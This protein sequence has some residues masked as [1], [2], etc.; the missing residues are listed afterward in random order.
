MSHGVSPI[1]ILY[2]T[3]L[4]PDQKTGLGYWGG[5][6]RQFYEVSRRAARMGAKVTI[7]TCRFPG[8]SKRDIV[9][10][11]EV[12]RLGLSRDPS[13]GGVLRS[14]FRVADYIYRTAKKATETD[15]DVIHCNAFYPVL[16]G[17]LASAVSGVPMVSTFHDI[18]T[19]RTWQEVTSP[20]WGTLGHLLVRASAQAAVGTVIAVSEQT[21]T[22]LGA[23]GRKGIAV[24]PNG[25]DVEL[26]DAAG[27]QKKKDQVLYVGRLV[28]Y[29]RVD[30]LIRAFR[31]V[32]GKLPEASLIIVGDGPERNA[33]E[34]L[35]AA[36][37]GDAIKFTGTVP[38]HELVAQIF[39]ESALFVLPSVAEGEGISLKEAMAA[40]VPVIAADVPGSGV[41]G[42]VR[43]NVNGLLVSPDDPEQLAEAI[44]R[45]LNDAELRK[46]MGANGRRTAEA[47]TW[48]DA[49]G[50]ILGIYQRVT[51]KR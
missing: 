34:G 26:L 39:K 45:V 49:A 23:L 14:P 41:L 31:I 19:K 43:D 35:A 42:V 17:R 51:K 22:K 2:L 1:R 37:P 36:A 16:A 38:S 30:V 4:F 48:D 40:S 47:W 24:V 13:T 3:E 44:L 18:P 29:K 7:I 25:V 9:D 12:I 15:C 28:K 10:G 32:A 50:R 21:R 11:I 27:T 46:F 33:L 6:E 8:Q 5:G 20:P